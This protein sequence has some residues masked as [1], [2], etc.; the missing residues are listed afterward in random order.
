MGESIGM[1]SE[2]MNSPN[3]LL[4]L[5]LAFTVMVGVLRLSISWYQTVRIR[6][7]K[8]IDIGNGQTLGNR[9]RQEDSFATD[10][11][12]YGLFA[13]VADG[14]GSFV[15]GKHA[16][17]LATQTFVREFRR[18]NVTGNI[19]YF[20][21]RTGGMI[22][23]DIRDY[24]DD[25][26]AGTTIAAGVIRQ[27]TLFYTWAGDSTIAVYRGGSLIPL[28]EKDNV[29]RKLEEL[30]REGKLT[31][32]EVCN[33]SYQERLLR[34]V[35]HDEFN[36]ISMN[37]HPFSLRKGDKVLFYTDG[38]E[39]LSHMQLE[40]ILAM[41]KSAQETADIIMTAVESREAENKDNATVVILNINK[42]YK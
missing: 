35:G 34:Y 3:V 14:I 22:N 15:N 28:N 38:I 4:A 16:S 8:A 39:V 27:N 5:L 21:K 1:M 42:E 30:F 6:T 41:N 33:G 19:G 36:E 12:A 31:R 18:S 26:P 13:I 23:H 10:E 37:E 29:A 11:Q 17:E 20:F 2:L 32:E 40:N 24:Y 25:I 7:R 9:Q